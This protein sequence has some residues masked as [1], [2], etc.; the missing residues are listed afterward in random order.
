MFGKEYHRNPQVLLDSFGE[1]ND[2]YGDI[3]KKDSNYGLLKTL[4]SLY[5]QMF[6][7]PEIGFQIRFLY[8]QD[9]LSNVKKNPKKILDAGSG[10]GSQ[11]FWLSKR[12]KG[13]EITGC[14][15]D[16]YKLKKAEEFVK[17]YEKLRKI[18]FIYWDV[19]RS[20]KSKNKYDLIVNIDVLE[21]I[22]NYK[23]VLRNFHRLLKTGGYLYLHTPQPNQVRIFKQFKKWAHEDHVREGYKP[24]VLEKEL[25]KCGFIIVEKKES[26]GFFGKLAWELNHITLVNNFIVA[27]LAFP[28]LYFL[29]KADL[30][31]DNK[32]GLCT[33]VLARK[34]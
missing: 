34:I 1:M 2:K 33:A 29:A 28:F 9:I 20:V 32:G 10:I 22:K 14:D 19:S 16:R 13:A 4:E 26:F 7:I 23:V 3:S 11:V 24:S 6:G 12:Y 8:F 5:I 21:H 31:V 18:R 25:K 15:I 17:S 30:L 27:S